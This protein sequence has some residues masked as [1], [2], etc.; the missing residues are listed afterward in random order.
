MSK[1]TTFIHS[2]RR[3]PS[4]SR[5]ARNSAPRSPI[6]PEHVIALYLRNHY[7]NKAVWGEYVANSVGLFHTKLQV[8]LLAKGYAMADACLY[9]RIKKGFSYSAIYAALKKEVADN[10]V[11]VHSKIVNLKS[12]DAFMESLERLRTPEY[13]VCGE[14]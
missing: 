11:F 8:D 13:L 10:T 14:A 7:R 3:A 12:K 1:K 9:L 5:N 2:T 6:Q 4:K